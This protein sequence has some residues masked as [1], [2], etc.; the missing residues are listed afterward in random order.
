MPHPAE[1][2]RRCTARRTTGATT[3]TEGKATSQEDSQFPIQV[4]IKPAVNPTVSTL[5]IS[6]TRQDM[7]PDNSRPNTRN[8]KRGGMKGFMFACI[9]RSLMNHSDRC[10]SSLYNAG[11]GCP[12]SQSPSRSG[13]TN[14]TRLFRFHCLSRYTGTLNGQPGPGAAPRPQGPRKDGS[15]QITLALSPGLAGTSAYENPGSQD[16]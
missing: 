12:S 15:C 9:S 14:T 4:P 3:R 7:K 8:S 2:T 11:K 16:R 5:A 6:V 1:I 10:P 13:R